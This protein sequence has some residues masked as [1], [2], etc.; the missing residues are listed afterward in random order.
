MQTKGLDNIAICGTGIAF[1]YCLAALA[2][3][4][5]NDINITAIE[6]EDLPV[7]D[8][9]YGNV[10]SPEIYKFH[11]SL[12]LT[13]PDLLLSTDT[14]FCYGTRYQSWADRMNWTQ[15]YHLPFPIWENIPFH[16]YLIKAK[17]ELEPYLVSAVCGTSGVFAHPPGDPN[18]PLSRA[19]YGYQL[20][21]QSIARLLSQKSLPENVTRIKGSIDKIQVTG[22]HITAIKLQDKQ[23]IQASF[24]IDASGDA[25]LLMEA[26]DNKFESRRTLCIL[27]S[28]KPR[29]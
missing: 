29:S 7:K 18:V 17:A 1:E 10:T 21:P 2:H 23:N 5:G 3:S 11:L 27:E 15:S 28:T 19:E 26:L 4:L 14:S 13:E 20:R 25:S 12:G 8:A 22:G 9:F 6:L 16:H 24:F